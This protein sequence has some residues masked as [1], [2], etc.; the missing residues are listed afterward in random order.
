[1][2]EIYNETL[3]SLLKAKVNLKAYEELDDNEEIVPKEYVE[4]GLRKQKTVAERKKE[5]NEEIKTKT[6]LLKIIQE[7]E[8]QIGSGSDKDF[9]QDGLKEEENDSRKT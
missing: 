8:Y 4:A 7:M 2:W 3:E 5:I 1:M 6:S 9:S